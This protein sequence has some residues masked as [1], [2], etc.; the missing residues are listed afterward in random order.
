[1][2]LNNITHG[3]RNLFTSRGSCDVAVTR[4]AKQPSVNL[5]LRLIAANL[6]SV[7]DMIVPIHKTYDIFDRKFSLVFSLWSA[8]ILRLICPETLQDN[9]SLGIKPATSRSSV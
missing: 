1:M 8:P 6:L 3:S 7:S 9:V 2:R 5:L 4:Q